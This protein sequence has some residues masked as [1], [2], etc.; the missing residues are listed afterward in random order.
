MSF[1][2]QI[3]ELCSS[4]SLSDIFL[5]PGEAVAYQQYGHMKEAS[6]RFEATDVE[7]FLASGKLTRWERDTNHALDIS[8]H[9]LRANFYRA[10]GK[11]RAVLRLLPAKIPELG[12]LR[13][14]ERY[15]NAM[16]ES[17]D[18]I[19]LVCGQTG[20]G[21]STTLAAGIQE[22]IERNDRHVVTLEKPIEYRFNG[23]LPQQVSQREVGVDVESYALGIDSAMRQAPGLIMVGEVKD[24]AAAVAL[25]DA[26]LTGH[27][28]V[29]T[30]H[31]GR[32]GLSVSSL[33]KLMPADRYKSALAV[34]PSLLRAVLC[35]RLVPAKKGGRFAVHELL[36]PSTAVTSHIAQEKF[37][38]LDNELLQ[39]AQAG[40]QTFERSIKAACADGL[41]EPEERN[42]LIERL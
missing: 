19:V 31:T 7:D 27:L 26:A 41:I 37:T 22:W 10:D 33:L 15:L 25:V 6:F 39:G 29:A 13:L 11:D 5:C 2:D 16:L 30:L 28:V 3:R 8:P 18:G 1:C 14:P 42:R 9:R 38:A 40:H 32:V 24:S 23:R 36:M 12:S 35:Q 34:F 4:T 21:K 17:R 20:S